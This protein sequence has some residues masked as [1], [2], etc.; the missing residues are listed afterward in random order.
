MTCT[1]KWGRFLAAA[2]LI[3]APAF[4][5][6]VFS[7][8]WAP[9]YHEDLPDRISGPELADYLGLPL[10]DAARLRADSYDAERTSVVPEYLCRPPSAAHSMRGLANMRV[11]AIRHPVTQRVV[12]F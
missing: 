1:R 3:S 5:Q 4:A 7:G 9:L 10:N 6:V 2:L 11:D 8:S 12:A